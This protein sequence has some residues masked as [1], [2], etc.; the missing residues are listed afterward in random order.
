[1][2]FPRGPSPSF[3]PFYINFPFI[4]FSSN[5]LPPARRSS[6]RSFSSLRR[7]RRELQLSLRWREAWRK[8]GIQGSD[9]EGLKGKVPFLFTAL[10]FSLLAFSSAA[11]A[12][13]SSEIAARDG[14]H[15]D[16]DPGL[17]PV[18]VLLLFLTRRRAPRGELEEETTAATAPRA[19]VVDPVTN[20]LVSSD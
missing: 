12:A 2:T 15:Y 19:A 7:W 8:I 16:S 1:M 11:A 4:S 9:K 6:H 13:L 18:P 14:F 10:S 17:A 3:F 5:D 20:A